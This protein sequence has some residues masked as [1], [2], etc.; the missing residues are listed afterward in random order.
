MS[1]QREAVLESASNYLYSNT[2][3]GFLQRWGHE[4][5]GHI[6]KNRDGATLDLGC[7]RGDHFPYAHGASY[8]GIDKSEESLSDLRRRFPEFKAIKADVFSL[9]FEDATFDSIVSV[10]VLEHIRDI[11]SC[12]REVDRVLKQNG[13]FIVVVPTWEG[14]LFKLGR[15][16]TI[17]RH[18]Q[19][20]FNIDYDRFCEDEHVTTSEE[21]AK[22]L[23]K[24]FKIDRI[25]GL[26]FQVTFS[27]INVWLVARCLKKER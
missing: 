17:K 5:A 26:P 4:V 9:P 25:F 13:E 8:V 2:A 12:L 16:I 7:G 23:E 24:H 18:M 10:Y 15:E 11:E 21:V 14:F 19:K 1:N 6:C 3:T 22:S 20:K 27:H